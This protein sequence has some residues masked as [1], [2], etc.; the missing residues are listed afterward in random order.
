MA[1]LG[2]EDALKVTETVIERTIDAGYP[3][4]PYVV[5]LG[6]TALAAHGLRAESYD[7]EAAP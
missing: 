3:A 7:V 5:L 6:V 1:K 4:P 2:L